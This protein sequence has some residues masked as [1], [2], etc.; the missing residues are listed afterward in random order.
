[1]SGA[2][3]TGT[4][5]MASVGAFYLLWGKYEEHGRIFVRVGVI[6]GIVASIMQL[7]PTGD[8][9]GRLLAHKQPVTLAAM[10]ALFESS[11]PALRWFSS[12]NPTCRSARSTIRWS[13]RACS[14]F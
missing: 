13:C 1:M 3:I 5:V 2:V 4:F 9:Q 6:V 12:A 7:F 10:E 11:K 14:A 8:G